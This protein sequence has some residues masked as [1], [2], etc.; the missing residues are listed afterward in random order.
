RRVHAAPAGSGFDRSAQP[1]SDDSFHRGAEEVITAHLAE[2][3]PARRREMAAV[4]VT[5][6][7]LTAIFTYPIAFKL[8]HVGRVDNGD[9][10]LSFAGAYFLPRHLT[11]DRRAAFVAA[12]WFAFCPFVFARTAHI[13]LLMTA[14]LPFVMLAFHRMADRPTPGRGAALGVAMALQALCCG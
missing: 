6:A 2:A 3:P 5:G 9:G 12:V 8:G 14:G 4:L 10:Q 11:G 1:R 7:M 13:Q